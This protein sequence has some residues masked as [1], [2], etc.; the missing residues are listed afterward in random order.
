MIACG[1]QAVELC[2]CPFSMQSKIVND[3]FYFTLCSFYMLNFL[4]NSQSTQPGAVKWMFSINQLQAAL[5]RLLPLSLKDV[6]VFNEALGN[7]SLLPI[8]LVLNV[9][10]LLVSTKCVCL[11]VC[12][13]M[14]C[15]ELVCMSVCVCVHRMDRWCN[16]MWHWGGGGEISFRSWPARW[17]IQRPLHSLFYTHINRWL[18]HTHTHTQAPLF[19][20]IHPTDLALCPIYTVCSV[21]V[22]MLIAGGCIQVPASETLVFNTQVLSLLRLHRKAFT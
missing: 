2:F 10:V 22:W 1:N 16:V 15:T 17:V 8:L 14:Y 7:T 13:G 11:C 20:F 18:K 5:V 21:C 3:A 6:F 9:R 12:V 4:S 19:L